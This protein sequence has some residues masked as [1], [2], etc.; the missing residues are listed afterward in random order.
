MAFGPSPGEMEKYAAWLERI[1][2]EA[3]RRRWLV[4]GSSAIA[5]AIVLVSG[6]VAGVGAQALNAAGLVFDIGGAGLLTLGL[7][8]SR[9]M[10]SEMGTMRWGG[11]DAPRRYW[12]ATRRDAYVALTLL[13]LGFAAQ[14]FSDV[15][16]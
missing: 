14:I 13:G 10:I 9:E 16:R 4:G 6:L 1:E 8:M 15:L 3:R 12:D 11:N 2:P 5:A 7:L